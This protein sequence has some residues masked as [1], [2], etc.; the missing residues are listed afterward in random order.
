[1]DRVI[2]NLDLMLPIQPSL[3]FKHHSYGFFGALKQ[4]FTQPFE[5]KEDAICTI[6][7]PLYRPFLHMA[8]LVLVP[9]VTTLQLLLMNQQQLAESRFISLLKLACSNVMN[10]LYHAVMILLSPFTELFRIATR[11]YNSYGTNGFKYTTFEAYE[12]A[13]ALI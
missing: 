12:A 6:T 4:H 13:N 3:D 2:K 7:S 8:A 1:M 5:N 10:A 9:S 11:T